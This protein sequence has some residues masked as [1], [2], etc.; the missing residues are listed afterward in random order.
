MTAQADGPGASFGL[1]TYSSVAS[2]QR[3][4]DRW[5]RLYDWNPVLALVRPARR[6]A[7][8]SMGLSDGD[9]VVDM[10][11]GT[12][13][14]LAFLREA[15]GETGRVI[16]VDISPR[17][18]ARARDRVRSMGWQNVTLIEG[19]IRDPPLAGPIDG[20]LSAF[21][22]VM[23]DDPDRLIDRWVDELGVATVAS[24]YSQP[25]RR[26]YGPLVNGLLGLY[27]VA[28]EEGWN[29]AESGPGPLGI[30]ER[31]GRRVREAVRDRTTRVEQ[32]TMLFGLVEL[33]VGHTESA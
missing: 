8:E 13:A 6:Q 26:R 10:G 1:D 22:M 15:V 11:T 16:G 14:N 20:V 28:F 3:L 18:L 17:M 30:L 12:G 7:V 4:Y 9:T 5:A 32:H 21:V 33:T 25:S 31:R 29:L 27:L 19:D 2:V 23:Y 24:L